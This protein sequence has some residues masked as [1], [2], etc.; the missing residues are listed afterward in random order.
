MEF[1]AWDHRF[2]ST[3]AKHYE[4]KEGLSP[5]LL[6]SWK[7][8]KHMYSAIDALNTVCTSLFDLVIHGP[9]PM[10]LPGSGKIAKHTT[11]V[12]KEIENEYSVIPHVEGTHWQSRFGHVIG[13][14]AGYY[15]YVF[16]KIFSSNIWHKYF[17]SD[18]LSRVAGENYK[19]SVLIYGGSKEPL[20]MLTSYLNQNPLDEYNYLSE[21]E[22]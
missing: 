20:Q 9:Y 18:P 12:I 8:W 3:F 4:T 1:F 22:E 6:D 21:L 10:R 17:K 5:Q 15:S 2:L 13:Y 16:C 19:N 11:E 14:G 7:S